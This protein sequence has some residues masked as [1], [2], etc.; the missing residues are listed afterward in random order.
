MLNQQYRKE[1]NHDHHIWCLRFYNIKKS[2]F[3]LTSDQNEVHS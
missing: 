1:L 2:L 3:R